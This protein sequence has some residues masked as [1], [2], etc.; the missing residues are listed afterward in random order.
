[1]IKIAGMLKKFYKQFYKENEILR[2][3][4]GFVYMI[5][6]RRPSV[7]RKLFVPIKYLYVVRRPS[8]PPKFSVL[9][10]SYCKKQ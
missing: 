8:V 4:S 3:F 5:V 7:P 10:Q 6:V 1:M 9:L 2:F